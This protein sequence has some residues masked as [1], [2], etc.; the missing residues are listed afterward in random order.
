MLKTL[1]DLRA[2]INRLTKFIKENEQRSGRIA[3][4]IEDIQGT[5][6]ARQTGREDFEA[7]AEGSKL[8][9]NPSHQLPSA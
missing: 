2:R 9:V 1:L 5:L 4:T 8:Q 6:P 7:W 3:I